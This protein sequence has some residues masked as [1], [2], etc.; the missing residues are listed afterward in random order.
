M[1]LDRWF[2][3]KFSVLS[4]RLVTQNGIVI[5]GTLAARVMVFTGGSVAL[6][7]VLYSI[8]VFITFLLSQLARVRHWWAV[9]HQVAS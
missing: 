8:H 6:L 9:R 1:A 7:V 5:I 3:A 4:D 2:P